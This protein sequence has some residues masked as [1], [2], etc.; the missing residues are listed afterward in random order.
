MV[1][2]MKQACDVCIQDGE[3]ETPADTIV[4]SLNGVSGA[5]ELCAEHRR[6]LV[7]PLEVILRDQGRDVRDVHAVDRGRDV[8]AGDDRCPLC[9]FLPVSRQGLSAHLRN[10]HEVSLSQMVAEGKAPPSRFNRGPD[11]DRDLAWH[12]CQKCGKS[13]RGAKGLAV[14]VVTHQQ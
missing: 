13:Y 7:D 4:I 2:L 12:K 10:V 3:K 1:V 14:H 9:D 6:A 5:I 8:R 11:Y